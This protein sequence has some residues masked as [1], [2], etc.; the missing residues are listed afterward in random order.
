MGARPGRDVKGAAE[1]PCLQADAERQPSRAG[2]TKFLAEL[3]RHYDSLVRVTFDVTDARE[4]GR[5]LLFLDRRDHQQ[6]EMS[7]ISPGQCLSRHV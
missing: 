5:Q 4:A 6:L 3:L 2:V 1:N 7:R